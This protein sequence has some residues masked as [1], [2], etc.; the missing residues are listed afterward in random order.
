MNAFLFELVNYLLAFFFWM[1]LGRLA[2]GVISGG[3]RTFFTGIF[4]KATAPAVYVVRRITPAFVPDVHI[5]IL[6]LPLLFA[7]RILLAPFGQPAP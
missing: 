1:V 7:L 3:R 6:S 5:P 4:E 2:L